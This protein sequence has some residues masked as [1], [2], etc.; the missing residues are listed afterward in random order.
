[1]SGKGYG[2]H[3]DVVNSELDILSA[4]TIIWTSSATA[5]TIPAAAT[6]GLTVVAGGITVTAGGVTVTAGG[7]DLVAAELGG[8][9]TGAGGTVTQGAGSGKATGVTLSKPCGKITMNGAALNAGV[10][11]IF[12]VTNT[13]VAVTDVIIVTHTS[14]GTSG[15]YYP[16]ISDVGAG[17]FDITVSNISGGNLTETP[18]LNFAVI[19]TVVA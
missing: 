6:S 3:R 8:Y 7:L 1:M 18:V 13:L 4:A 9:G 10:E 19:S 15:A 17:T 2:F 14:G 5:V 16:F 11:V 12:T